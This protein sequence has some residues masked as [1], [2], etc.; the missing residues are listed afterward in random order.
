MTRFDDILSLFPPD[1]RA[2]V[3]KIWEALGPNEKG[4]FPVAINWLP[5]GYDLVKFGQVVQRHIRQ[6]LAVSS[7]SSCRPGQRRQIHPVQSTGARTK[8]TRPR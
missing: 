3:R 8:A 2:P 1:V 5:G 6:P 4:Q 7:G